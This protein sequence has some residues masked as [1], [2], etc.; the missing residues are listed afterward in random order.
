MGAGGLSEL[1]NERQNDYKTCLV[2][3]DVCESVET[4]R[5]V[6]QGPGGSHV[7]RL[8]DGLIER[9]STHAI[10]KHAILSVEVLLVVALLGLPQGTRAAGS[11]VE[12]AGYA[13]EIGLINSLQA[14]L[15]RGRSAKRQNGY[16]P[17]P[18]ALEYLAF[19]RSARIRGAPPRWGGVCI[20]ISSPGRPLTP[21][22]PSTDSRCSPF[23]L[24]LNQQRGGGELVYSHWLYRGRRVPVGNL[25][26]CRRA[27]PT[28]S[29]RERK[30]QA[31]RRSVRA[32]RAKSAPEEDAQCLY[33]HPHS[34]R[35]TLP[36]PLNACADMP[37]TLAG[38][39]CRSWWGCR[40]A[41]TRASR[42]F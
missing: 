37:D 1:Q 14:F 22:P 5:G 35:L 28:L 42:E 18:V 11:P 6:D 9:C 31:E 2:G 23:G 36:L 29:T 30:P 16:S 38:G 34:L 10:G 39:G 26:Q 33:T 25:V 21:P 17:G 15:V 41:C 3:D 24:G 19:P 32:R 7:W 8:A 4:T 20:G 12:A 40:V 13:G 27:L